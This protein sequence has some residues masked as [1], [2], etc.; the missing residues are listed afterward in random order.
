L[1]DRKTHDLQFKK[2]MLQPQI[3]YP[4]R[5]FLAG[6]FWPRSTPDK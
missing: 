3:G 4:E 2:N 1:G 5:F 6:L